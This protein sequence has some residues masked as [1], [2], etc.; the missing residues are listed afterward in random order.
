MN[1][2]MASPPLPTPPPASTSH[3]AF[4]LARSRLRS[5]LPRTWLDQQF[6]IADVQNIV[7]QA[8]AVYEQ[9][10]KSR[11]RRLL[12]DFSAGVVHYGNILDVL[13]S[14]HP[15]YVSLAWGTTK[16]LF[17]VCTRAIKQQARTRFDH[18]KA[19]SELRGI[20]FRVRKIFCQ[21]QRHL[22][23]N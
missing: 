21:G 1:N 18:I 10:E 19:L 20:A 8:Q 17:V 23:S 3:K 7:A 4:E 13:V 22:G 2:A 14:H 12:T 16:F 9:R 6:T 11:A 5:Q 15:E